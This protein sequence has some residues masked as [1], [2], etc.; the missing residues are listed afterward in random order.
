MSGLKRYSEDKLLELA[1]RKWYVKNTNEEVIVRKVES[2]YKI[3]RADVQHMVEIEFLNPEPDARALSYCRARQHRQVWVGPY[4]GHP[5]PDIH[6][7]EA[8]VDLEYLTPVPFG[9]PAA[10]VLFGK[11]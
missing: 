8:I 2:Y 11:K 7:W 3:D 6:V 5:S 1:D 9:T 10:E 4:Q